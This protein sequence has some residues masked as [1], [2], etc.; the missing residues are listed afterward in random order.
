[1]LVQARGVEI[2][3]ARGDLIAQSDYVARA[4]CRYVKNFSRARLCR[5]IGGS[6]MGLF[7]AGLEKIPPSGGFRGAANIVLCFSSEASGIKIKKINPRL[8]TAGGDKTITPG[9]GQK[10]GAKIRS[11]R[12]QAPFPTSGPRWDELNFFVVNFFVGK[13]LVL[14][15][16]CEKLVVTGKFGPAV[17]RPRINPENRSKAIRMRFRGKKARDFPGADIFPNAKNFA[18]TK[19]TSRVKIDPGSSGQVTGRK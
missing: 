18:R 12:G 15:L 13:V 11:H 7:R 10:A 17:F 2:L 9:D 3:H 8:F 14:K 6:F 1:M 5:Q 19:G 16:I 4:A